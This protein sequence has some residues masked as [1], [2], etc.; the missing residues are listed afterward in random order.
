MNVM[1]RRI[2]QRLGWTFDP[3][4]PEG[5]LDFTLKPGGP[6]TMLGLIYSSATAVQGVAIIVRR[7]HDVRLSGAWA[8]IFP[9]V[10]Y[11]AGGAFFFAA[12]STLEDVER[13][14]GGFLTFHYAC[15]GVASLILLAPGTR[16]P[17]NYG[18]DPRSA[19][20]N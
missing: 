12:P 4:D 6:I 10:V 3:V 14:S 9:A 15:L 16:G 18:A 8:L 2:S 13:A 7:L 1:L 11:F 20:R 19:P 5:A 17:N